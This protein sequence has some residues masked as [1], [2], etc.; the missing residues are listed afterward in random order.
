M[1]RTCT[2]AA[3][4]AA[5]KILHFR[6]HLLG[7]HMEKAAFLAFV[8]LHLPARLRFPAYT[9]NNML[10][11]SV[12]FHQGMFYNG[13][14]YQGCAMDIVARVIWYMRM[15]NVFCVFIYGVAGRDLMSANRACNS[16]SSNTDHMGSNL[17]ACSFTWRGTVFSHSTL[18]LPG[19]FYGF[20]FTCGNHV[21]A[22]EWGLFI[23]LSSLSCL[24]DDEQ[25][26]FSSFC[27]IFQVVFF[28]L[29]L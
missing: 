29:E 16:S 9:T 2:T 14:Y 20:R 22:Y 13:C 7:L 12:F 24:F 26:F 4:T 27:R 21:L 3:L 28:V 10:D 23:L 11:D 8:L 6:R 25:I 1:A 19:I 15:A 18:A 17:E 5:T